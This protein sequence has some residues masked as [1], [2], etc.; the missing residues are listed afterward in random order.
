MVSTRRALFLSFASSNGSILL[1]FAGSLLLSRLLTPAEIGLFSI[2]TAFLGIAQLIRDF[3][4]ASYIV[5]CQHPDRI[6]LRSA[7]SSMLLL[8]WSVALLLWLGSGP[9][10][11]F[12]R[13]PD[14]QGLLRLLSLNLLLTPLG[15]M[16]IA[17]LRRDMRF[18]VVG[19]LDVAATA[20]QIGTSCL[21]AWLGWG[22]TSL[23]GGAIAGVITTVALSLPHRYPQ[24]PWLPGTGKLK[25]I[26]RFGA[27]STSAALLGH[28]NNSATDLILGRLG[29]PAS[30]GLM[31]RAVGI[32]RLLTTVMLRG[33]SPI[34]G[35]MF[36]Q[37]R[38]G[39]GNI[40]VQWQKV[41]IYITAMTW[42]AL[43]CMAVLAEPVIALL[44]GHQ[45]LE[46]AALVPWLCL[47]AAIGMPFTS[48]GPMLSALARPEISMR[49]ELANLPIKIAAIVLAA[50]FGLTAV[51]AAF[52]VS[53]TA[54]ACYQLLTLKRHCG[55]RPMGFIKVLL[56]SITVTLAS[57]V[58]FWLVRHGLEAHW[59]TIPG[60]LLLL[61]TGGAGL[62]AWLLTC[63]ALGHPL[64]YELQ[65]FVPA[66]WTKSH[67]R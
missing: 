53:A 3:G 37:L 49:I 44:Y 18:G 34:I 54:G 33:V 25:E 39:E 60:V 67:T 61:T 28:M 50:P 36:A 11:V 63:R 35:P 2:A 19:L 29:G 10:A 12:Y 1:S 43:A 17:L 56:P 9:L 46:S 6:V 26:L 66:A 51:A 24:Q 13:E 59:P 7:L 20:V 31:S 4:A 16:T 41:A 15:A 32:A 38:R 5:Q 40:E 22:A 45:W 55:F 14:L 23:A 64:W 47:S 21:L 30:V 48:V 62:L 8:A 57:S 52:V 65:R 27:Y 42:P 58:T